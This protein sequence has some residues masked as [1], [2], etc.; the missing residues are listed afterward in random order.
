MR[1]QMTCYCMKLGWERR[2]DM[3]FPKN[4]NLGGASQIRWGQGGKEAV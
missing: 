4:D 1:C 2:M 3:L